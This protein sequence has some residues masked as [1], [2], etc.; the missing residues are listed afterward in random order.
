MKRSLIFTIA[1]V[2]IAISLIA[3]NSGDIYDVNKNNYEENNEKK[4][5]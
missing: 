2:M 1:I 5:L 3:C 4:L